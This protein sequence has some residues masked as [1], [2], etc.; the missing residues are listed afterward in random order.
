MVREDD[1]ITWP[2]IKVDWVESEPWKWSLKVTVCM[3][4]GGMLARTKT[5]NKLDTD[6]ISQT[7]PVTAQSFYQELC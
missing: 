2:G 6:R 7:S 4:R 1:S 5:S 3:G